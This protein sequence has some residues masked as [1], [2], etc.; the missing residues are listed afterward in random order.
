MKSSV[1]LPPEVFQVFND[2]IK[3]DWDG[4]QAT[5]LQD[6]AAERIAKALGISRSKVFDKHLLDVEGFYEEAGWDVVYDKPG[7]NEDYTAFFRFRK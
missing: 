6:E 2:L 7:Y 5:V 3:E 4:S 1:K